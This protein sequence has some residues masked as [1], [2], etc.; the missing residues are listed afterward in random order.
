VARKRKF[1]EHYGSSKPQTPNRNFKPFRLA[2][3]YD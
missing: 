2:E 3:A 1:P